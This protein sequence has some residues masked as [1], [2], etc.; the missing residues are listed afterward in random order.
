MHQA[1]AALTRV[2]VGVEA[3]PEMF[4]QSMPC[5]TCGAGIGEFCTYP[6][7][8]VAHTRHTQRDTSVLAASAAA[9]RDAATARLEAAR[10]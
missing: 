9:V 1:P 6:S 8:R 3:P 7:G 4:W 10:G 5:P 2:W